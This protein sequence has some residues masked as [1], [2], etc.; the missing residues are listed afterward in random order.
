MLSLAAIILPIARRSRLFYSRADKSDFVER[1]SIK[2]HE[3]FYHK[4]FL[5]YE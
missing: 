3:L 2:D 1:S 5:I 4:G